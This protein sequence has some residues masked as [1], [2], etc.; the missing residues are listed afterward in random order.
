MSK[1]ARFTVALLAAT[2]FLSTA[3]AAQAL[4]F[5]FS[6]AGGGVQTG[7]AV[8]IPITSVVPIQSCNNVAVGLIAVTVDASTTD[9]CIQQAP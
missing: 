9:A 6:V 4:T 2:A 8:Q 1:T 7:N 3:P 5:G